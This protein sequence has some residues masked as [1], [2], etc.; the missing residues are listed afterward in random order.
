MRTLGASLGV[1]ASTLGA[2]VSRLDRLGYLHNTGIWE[3]RISL[4]QKGQTVLAASRAE[5]TPARHPE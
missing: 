2:V 3:R 4:S 1:Q 5:Q